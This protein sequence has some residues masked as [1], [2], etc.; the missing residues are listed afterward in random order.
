MTGG[1]TFQ[2]EGR[3]AVNNNEN[4]TGVSLYKWNAF[5]FLAVSKNSRSNT[6]STLGIT[7]KQDPWRAKIKIM[8]TVCF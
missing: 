6:I 5:L 1:Y 4:K 3:Y 2:D 8:D 7:H